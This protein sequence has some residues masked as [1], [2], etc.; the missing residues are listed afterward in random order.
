MGGSMHQAGLA[1]QQLPHTLVS[2]TSCNKRSTAHLSHR[3]KVK[4][5]SHV[6]RLY[7]PRDDET[8]FHGKQGNTF[9]S[10]ETVMQPL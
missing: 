1:P 10:T 3:G 6:P 4:A 2:C 9:P 5:E 7:T 8:N